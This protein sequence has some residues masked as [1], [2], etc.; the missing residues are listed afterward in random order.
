MKTKKNNKF[1]PVIKK[2]SSK[3][4]KEE[5]FCVCDNC[6]SSNGEIH[7]EYFYMYFKCNDCGHKSGFKSIES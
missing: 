5:P 3:F 6:G 2:I 1:K 7:K 4:D